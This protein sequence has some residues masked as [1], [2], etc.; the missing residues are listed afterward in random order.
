M[1][2]NAD[3]AARETLMAED[4]GSYGDSYRSD[5]LTMYRD[6]VASAD[7]ISSRRA[8]ANSFFLTVNTAYLGAR[9]YFE[10][11]SNE[12]TLI[13][14]IVGILFCLVWARMI[15]SYKTLNSAKFRVIQMMEQQLPLAPFTAE[16]FV[17]ARAPSRHTA[18]SSVESLVPLFFALLYLAVAVFH[19]ATK[20]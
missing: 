8:T 12:G 3:Q 5:Y 15:N 20:S 13:Q 7:T 14:A 2:R 1:D 9:G 10:V 18:L 11:A 17:Y 6:Y 16:E 19:F 4:E